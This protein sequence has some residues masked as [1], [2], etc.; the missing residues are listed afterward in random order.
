MNLGKARTDLSV[1]VSYY[2]ISCDQPAYPFKKMVTW[3]G[4]DL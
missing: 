1:R 4:V 3:K 2:L